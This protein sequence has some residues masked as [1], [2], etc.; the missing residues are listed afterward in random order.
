MRVF[1][2]VCVCWGGGVGVCVCACVRVSGFGEGILGLIRLV[3]VCMYM[4]RAHAQN[5][6]APNTSTSLSLVVLLLP[7][8]SGRRA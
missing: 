1:W 8:V 3:V 4:T 6:V 2:C 5:G 7:A